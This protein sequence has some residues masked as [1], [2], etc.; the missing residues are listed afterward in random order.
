MEKEMSSWTGTRRFLSTGIVA[1]LFALAPLSPSAESVNMATVTC[2]D[3][4]SEDEAAYMF[5]WLDGYFS[6]KQNDTIIDD[7]WIAE[8]EEV[9]AKAC[10]EGDNRP[11]LQIL[12]EYLAG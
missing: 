6:A 5:F 7:E 9:L 11:L 2:E 4:G 8:V 1:A 3:I 10:E 12:T